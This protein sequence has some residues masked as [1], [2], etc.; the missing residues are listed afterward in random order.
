[1][2][3]ASQSLSPNAFF[4][5]V[6]FP[7]HI[8]LE[9]YC[10]SDWRVWGQGPREGMA[11][12]GTQRMEGEMLIQGYSG[13]REE[14]LKAEARRWYSGLSILETSEPMGTLGSVACLTAFMKQSCP[15]FLPLEIL[16]NASEP[17]PTNECKKAWEIVNGAS[18]KCL[19]GHH[20]VFR[21]QLPRDFQ[22]H[23][24]WA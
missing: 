5:C 2:T 23:E 11:A 9:L 4:P 12:P 14:Q 8:L 16:S 22:T 24:P 7:K 20:T 10:L 15:S 19:G 6:H 3:S 21:N 17:P 1:M 13:M 18:P